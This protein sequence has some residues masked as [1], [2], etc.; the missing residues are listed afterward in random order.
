VEHESLA[1]AAAVVGALGAGGLLLARDRVVLL[2]GLAAFVFGEIGLAYALAPDTP[3]LLTD[4][5]ARV[6]ALVVAAL[7]ALTVAAVFVRFPAAAPVALLVAAP[8]RFSIGLGN[9]EAFLLVPFYAVLIT[10]GAALAYTVLR[11]DVGRPLPGLVSVPIAAL[12]VLAGVSLL[13]AED[14][15][16][17]T[18]ELVFFYFPFALLLT[19]VARTPLRDWSGRALAVALITVTSAFAAIGIYQAWSHT[20]LLA[21]QDVQLAN[22]YESFF[23]VTSLFQDP[24][25]YGRHLVL[26]IVVL[27]A[28]LWLALVRPLVALPVLALL[29]VGLYFSYSQTSFVALFVAVCA[30]ALVAGDRLMRRTV[31]GV[32][33]ALVVVAAVLVFAVGGG[34][35]AGR[36]TSERLPLAKLTWP[37]YA[38]N[39][40][41]GVGIGS[42]PLA[43]RREEDAH[44]QK[45]K[46]VSHTTPLTMAAELGTIGLL[47]YLGLLAALGRAI[48]SAWRRLPGLGLALAGSLTALV[49]QSLF[50]GGFFED[51]FVWGIAGLAAATLLLPRERAHDPR[52][53]AVR[54]AAPQAAP[55]P[56]RPPSAP[57]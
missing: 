33:A 53:T 12:L 38:H 9:Q 13:W 42:Q 49:V 32:S 26:G 34:D 24:S 8:F 6:G 28:A 57:G 44:R 45:S 3:G 35:S 43:S 2:A 36:V 10:A 52:P 5:A 16:A 27:V 48:L 1:H 14:L 50:Y 51:P 30:I 47:V 31:V 22:A 55:L 21:K 37:V 7:A 23:R 56:A 29:A 39:P 41:V 25:V 18:I 19:I 20:E 40:V 11:K 4:S 15:R 46:N 54:R 17:G